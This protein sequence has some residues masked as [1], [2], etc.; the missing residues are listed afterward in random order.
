MPWCQACGTIVDDYAKVD[1]GRS[2]LVLAV[3]NVGDML[4]F[5]EKQVMKEPLN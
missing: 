4:D 3:K 1:G 2:G 5:D